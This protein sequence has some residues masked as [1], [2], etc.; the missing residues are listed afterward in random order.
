MRCLA[1]RFRR[2]WWPQSQQHLRYPLDQL[3]LQDL[4]D[5][6]DPARLMDQ[7]MQRT[8]FA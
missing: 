8:R 3:H 4:L 5:L 1:Q 6:L 7:V 2:Q